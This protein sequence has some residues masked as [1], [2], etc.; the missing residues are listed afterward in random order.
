MSSWFGAVADHGV[1]DGLPLEIQADRVPV[2]DGALV[3]FL[4]GGAPPEPR[5]PVAIYAHNT[6]TTCNADTPIPAGASGDHQPAQ[7]EPRLLPA[8]PQPDRGW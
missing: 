4:A 1:A 2:I 3:F 8:T 7:R 5:Q 6:W